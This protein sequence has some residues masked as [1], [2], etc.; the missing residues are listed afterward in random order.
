MAAGDN[1]SDVDFA[2]LDQLLDEA[3]QLDG[4]ALDA[5]MAAQPSAT[6]TALQALLGKSQTST[7]HRMG[8]V[9]RDALVQSARDQRSDPTAGDWQLKR[10]IGS[11]G[12]GQVFYAERHEVRDAE[13]T[14]AHQTFV[15]RAAVKVLW[16]HRVR[17]Q[18]RERFLRE[19]HILA[20]I[21]HPGLA[22]FL[23][24]GLLGDGRPWFAMEFVEGDNIIDATATLSL[25]ERLQ[26]FVDVADTINYAHQRLIVHRDIKP[27]NILVDPFGKPRVLDFG[28][29]GVLGEY[30][31]ESLTQAQGTPL[32]LQYASPEQLTGASV[33]VAS[34]VY[35]LGLLLFEMLAR[36]TPYTVDSSS[37]QA[38]LDTVCTDVPPPL[39]Q[40]LGQRNADVD[41]IIA[42]ALRKAPAQ[43]YAS[44]AAMADDVRRYLDGRP[45]TARPQSRWYVLSRFLRRNAVLASVVAASVV[46]LSVATVFSI[47]RA[48]EANAQAERSRISQR[49]LADVFKRADPFGNDGANMTLA[50]ALVQAMPGIEAQVAGDPRLAF[51]VNRTI[52]G[53]LTN[54]DLLDLEQAALQ[55]AWD[56][57][58]A[59]GGDN[60][61]ERLFAIAGLGNIKVRTDPGEGVA[62]L[63]E[64]LPKTP[65]TQTGAAEW[66]SGKYA[67]VSGHFRLRDYDKA[68]AGARAMAT[69]A[70]EFSIEAPRT[71]GRI[72]QLLAGAARR[73]GDTDAADEHWAQAVAQMRRAD[74]P[75]ALGV[76]LSN[77]ALHYGMTRRYERSAALFEE[78][79]AIFRQ[80]ETDNTSHANVL[81]LYA[82]LLF[83]MRDIDAALAALDEALVILDP[84]E[85]SYAYFVAQ[86]NRA[87]YAFAGGDTAVALDAITA[88]LDTAVPAF[89]AQADV[90]ERM[91]PVL[92]RFLV[93][94]DQLPLAAQLAGVT[95]ARVCQNRALLV[96]AI[97]AAAAAKAAAPDT[98]RER[99]ALQQ[100]V[101]TLREAETLTVA[102]IDVA[103][104]RYRSSDATFLDVLDRYT[105]IVDLDAMAIANAM[106]TNSELQAE[107]RRLR[108]LQAATQRELGNHA[109]LP[110]LI[111]ALRSP[112]EEV[113]RSF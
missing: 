46:A 53:I 26:L 48:A 102:D 104:Q 81:R 5:F 28:I 21:D 80:H 103:F 67:E 50:D 106:S 18:F 27:Q 105:F 112:S 83:R 95:E 12:T 24:G 91:L 56:A 86:L 64:H 3:L 39:S 61:R 84:A 7:L 16:S 90:T 42:K 78:S 55:S 22:R 65:R 37:L 11:G 63:A 52:V 31:Q 93:F 44:A 92:L 36:A 13:P 29:A 23:D 14:D 66:L 101:L 40:R 4:A 87:N 109:G 107:L 108:E 19:R 75:L 51:E 10:E 38:A 58:R 41:A 97:E 62:F 30:Q 47:N 32:T 69:V 77:Q 88:G 110:A 74:A 33:D 113:C 76:T 85:Q 9:A 111:D 59:L 70:R 54:L 35:Q 49:I 43:R 2:A 1:K 25:R 89:G 100:E 15:Q 34:D 8:A 94:A 60:E 57:A 45:I 82:G 72:Q 99:Q 73:A 96:E 71:L 20:S 6:R 68:D 98:D 79:L 17:S